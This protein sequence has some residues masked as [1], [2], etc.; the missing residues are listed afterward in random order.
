MV[1]P[2]R[3][4]ALEVVFP[5]SHR[6]RHNMLTVFPGERPARQERLSWL[7]EVESGCIMEIPPEEETPKLT[8]ICEFLLLRWTHGLSWPWLGRPVNLG[9]DI[10]T[11]PTLRVHAAGIPALFRRSHTSFRHHH[12][13]ATRASYPSFSSSSLR[14]AITRSRSRFAGAM[15]SQIWSPYAW[16]AFTMPGSLISSSMSISLPWAS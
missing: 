10:T 8:T 9:A 2:L 3:V 5:T 4:N 15:L 7:P 14:N 12:Y 13:P 16:N 1:T 6:V 11:R